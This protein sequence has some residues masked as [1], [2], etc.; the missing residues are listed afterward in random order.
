[1]ASTCQVGDIVVPLCG[2]L[3]KRQLLAGRGIYP[4]VEYVLLD[5]SD[6]AEGS[7]NSVGIADDAKDAEPKQLDP[8]RRIALIRPA[9][10]LREH[11]ERSDWPITVTLSDV[12]L[13]L[14]KTT[15]EAGT[16]LGTLMLSGDYILLHNYLW[17]RIF[18]LQS[19]ISL[20]PIIGY[21]VPF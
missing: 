17:R 2:D 11:L 20:S 5:V 18:C 14:S 13:W 6:A 3:Q 21:Q 15:Y 8:A 19:L 16:A 4:G 10:P 7:N 12:P 9:Y 1:V